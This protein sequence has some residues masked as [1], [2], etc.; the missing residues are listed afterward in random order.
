M[1]KPLKHQSPFLRPDTV[2]FGQ[3]AHTAEERGQIV[4]CI[5][6]LHR[7]QLLASL[8]EQYMH[9]TSLNK[10]ALERA[11]AALTQK[12]MIQLDLRQTPNQA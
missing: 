2:G 3:F 11:L 10:I 9:S 12:F 8:S 5:N 6:S 4:G 7:A 1:H